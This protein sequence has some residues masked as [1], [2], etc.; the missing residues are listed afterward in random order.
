MN[1]IIL[2]SPSDC[3]D[4]DIVGSNLY[5]R[6][7]DRLI[8]RRNNNIYASE[9]HKKEAELIDPELPQSRNVPDGAAIT[10]QSVTQCMG[11]LVC[12]GVYK[13]DTC[14]EPG[15]DDGNEKNYPGHRDFAK[16]TELYKPE[17][18]LRDVEAAIDFIFEQEQM[19]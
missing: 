1:A 5:Q 3:L 12:T 10:K 18:T 17:R 2:I 8:N 14:P 6:Y 11:I 4:S 19:V 7:I 13:P 16:I 15:T 9:P